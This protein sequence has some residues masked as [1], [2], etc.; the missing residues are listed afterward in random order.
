MAH[1]QSVEQLIPEAKRLRRERKFA[2][3][4]EVFEQALQ[5]D[6]LEPDIHDG[7]ATAWYLQGDLERAA[8]HFERV[9]RLDPRRGPAWI[10]LG[11]VYNRL[12]QYTRA[13]EVLRRAVQVERTSAAAFYNLG[14]AYRHLRQWAMAVPA[15]REAIR[16]E[17]DQPDAYVN[18][19]QVYLEMKNI[20]QA[21]LQFK[22]ALELKPDSAR[23]RNGL[24][25]CEAVMESLSS[26]ASPFGRLVNNEMLRQGQDAAVVSQKRLSPEERSRDRGTVERICGELVVSSQDLQELI[27]NELNPI[28]MALARGITLTDVRERN[29][30]IM[31]AASDLADARKQ[32]A[33]RVL[34]VRR[35][36]R[37]ARDHEGTMR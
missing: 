3:A 31:A 25:Q 18:L 1:N 14:S 32:F 4:I 12:Q 8:E 33:P 37:Q 28:V 10:N 17:P 2:A 5:I 13:A 27:D 29:S 24:G 11:A 15:Y 19:G 22:K 34:A 26:A 23:A 16:L 9:T 7:L 35:A 21:T 6:E 30:A 36:M 20:P